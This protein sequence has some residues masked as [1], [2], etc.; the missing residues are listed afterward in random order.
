MP[1]RSK[2]ASN[3]GTDLVAPVNIRLSEQELSSD[4]GNNSTA[5]NNSNMIQCSITGDADN[6]LRVTYAQQ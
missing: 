1:Y 2:V 4:I 3:V 5:A 6:M